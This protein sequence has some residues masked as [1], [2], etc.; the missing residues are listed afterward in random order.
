MPSAVHGGAS[1][2]ERGC[3]KLS[4]YV[5]YCAPDNN[6][7]GFSLI[8]RWLRLK[9]AQQCTVEAMVKGLKNETGSD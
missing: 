2:Q 4:D 9:G 8:S 5:Y 6:C 7:K 1:R 3:P